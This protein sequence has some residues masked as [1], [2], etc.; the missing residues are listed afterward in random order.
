M[1]TSTNIYMAVMESGKYWDECKQINLGNISWN[2]AV[3]IAKAQGEP[4]RL[5]TSEGFSNQ[6]HYFQPEAVTA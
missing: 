6:G 3:K 1:K 2:A 4:T 5:S